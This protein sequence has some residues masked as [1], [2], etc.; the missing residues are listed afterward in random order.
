M[1]Q[2]ISIQ[3]KTR[4]VFM[5]SKAF[6]MKDKLNDP[7]GVIASI[8]WYHPIQKKWNPQSFFFKCSSSTSFYVEV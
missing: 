3:I 6:F 1:N 4:S 5:G 7:T 8:A 2:L